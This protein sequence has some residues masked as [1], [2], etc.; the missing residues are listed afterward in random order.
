MWQTRRIVTTRR[1]RGASHSDCVPGESP[2][3]RGNLTLGGSLGFHLFGAQ[4]DRTGNLSSRLVPFPPRTGWLV[5]IGNMA[6]PPPPPLRCI[7]IGIGSVFGTE[8]ILAAAH[9]C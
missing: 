6:L 8:V 9:R 7:I 2:S 3:W 4:A 1:T 5:G